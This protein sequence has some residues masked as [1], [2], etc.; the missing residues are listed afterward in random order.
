[1]KFFIIGFVGVLVASCVSMKKQ[2]QAVEIKI[3]SGSDV[4]VFTREELSKFSSLRKISVA[5][6]PSY[7]G[8][9]MTYDAIPAYVLFSGLSVGPKQTVV[10]KCLD[11]FSAPISR[12]RLLNAD[13]ARA[14]AYVAIEP[15]SGRWPLLPGGVRSAGPFYLVWQN[16]ELSKV[17]SEEWPFQLAGF[18]VR[19]SVEEQFPLT[20]PSAGSSPFVRA[21][22]LVFQKNC[23]ACHT[24]NGQGSSAL[25]PDLNIPR[26]PTEYFGGDFLARY[27]RNPQSLR[28]WP[29][30]K[31]PAFDS[32]VLSDVELRNLVSYLRR[33]AADRK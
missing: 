15:A 17:G 27:I 3:V 10:F 24:L 13:P 21:G 23:F 2:E 8:R 19:A 28:R 29:Q 31:M 16:P 12:E 9:V 25:G 14:V 33:M 22:Y 6:D 5:R 1:M 26:S 7:P 11:G 18:E 4:H 20:V 30:A 32:S